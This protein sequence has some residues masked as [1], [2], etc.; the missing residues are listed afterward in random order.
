MNWSDIKQTSGNDNV[1]IITRN[2]KCI[3]F[4]EDDV[5]PMGRIAGGVRAIKL[6]DDDEVV[7]MEAG[8]A[9]RRAS[10]CHRKG[11]WKENSGRGLQDTGKRRQGSA[12]LR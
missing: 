12:D 3:S 7:S 9:W 10:C 4:S 5:R 8:T 11:L 1:I 2:G 6:E